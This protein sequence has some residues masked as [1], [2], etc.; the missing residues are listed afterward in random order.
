MTETKGLVQDH[1]RLAEVK[2]AK[3]TL[4]SNAAKKKNHF[5]PKMQLSQ[6]IDRN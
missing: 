3:F 6:L 4:E 5:L 2:M 1:C